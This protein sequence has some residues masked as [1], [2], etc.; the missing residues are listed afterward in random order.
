MMGLFSRLRDAI[1]GPRTRDVDFGDDRLN[2]IWTSLE[3]EAPVGKRAEFIDEAIEAFQTGYVDTEVDSEER[4]AA[5]EEF[6]ALCSTYAVDVA[7]FDWDAW[8]DWYDS[9]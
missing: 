6:E 5:R 7:D 2:E 1:F 9:Q 4:I 8:R 3:G